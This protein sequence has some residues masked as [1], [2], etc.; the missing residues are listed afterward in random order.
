MTPGGS[1]GW[2]NTLRITV[3]LRSYQTELVNSIRASYAAGL[4]SVCAV[5]PTGAGKSLCFAEIARLTNARKKSTC[6]V[7]HRDTLLRQAS[8]KM[9]D[10]GVEYGIIAAGYTPNHRAIVQIAS[11]QTLVRRLDRYNFDFLIFDEAHLSCAPTWDRLRARWPHAHI[12]GF[13]ATPILSGGRGLSVGGYQCLVI[14]PTTPGLIEDGYL[15]EPDTFGPIRKVDISGVR[16]RAGDYAAEDLER[17]VDNPRITGDAIAEV[18]RICPNVPTMIFCVSRKHAADVAAQ[19]R[20]SGF[21]ADSVDGSMPRSEIRDKIDGLSNGRIMYLASCD[22][23]GIGFDA[24]A[25]TCAVFLRH[26]RSIG[27]YIQQA[28]RALRPVYAPGFDLSTRAG[29]LSAIAAGPKPR[30]YLI[31]HVGNFAAHD[32]A[33]AEREWSLGGRKKRSRA[34]G[35]TIS[36]TQ[37]PKCLRPHKPAPK[38]PHCGHVYVAAP[39]DPETQKGTLE[40]VDKVALRRAKWGEE[41]AC[42]TLEDLIALGVSRK[43]QWPRQW[44]ERRWGFMHPRKATEGEFFA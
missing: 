35:P 39:R 15:T 23:L 37:C 30:A 20:A 21:S 4:K 44:A 18:M 29:R 10:T 32:L 12:L 8:E 26:T 41:R 34:G 2:L 7:V 36:L 25:V 19:F 6:I 40:K 31:D 22:L 3:Q 14:G 9:R 11:A 38:C 24:P 27:L 16:T 42:A 17:I 28:G 1:E 43:Y 5:A 13:T 33:D